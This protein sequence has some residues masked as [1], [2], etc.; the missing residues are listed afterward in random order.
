[1]FSSIRKR[2]IF[3]F[4]I[5]A[6]VIIIACTSFFTYEML[7]GIEGQMKADGITLVNN[8]KANIEGADVNDI[9]RM[10]QIIDETYKYAD[11]QLYYAGAITKDKTIVAGTA[12]DSIGEKVDSSEYDEA[13]KGKTAA[14]M[15]VWRGVPAYNVTVPIKDG[16]TIKYGLS[17]GISVDNMKKQTKNS[18]IKSIFFDLIL[19][20]LV[21][22]AAMIIGKRIARPIER[23]KETIEKIG[24]GDLTAEYDEAI[25][26]DEI[27]RLAAVNN[28]TTNKIRELVR[29]VKV[30]SESLSNLSKNISSG[31]NQIALTSEGIAA[32]VVNVSEEGM[33]QTEAL[34]NAVKLLEK[35]SLDLYGVNDKLA[36]LAKD[37]EYIREDAKDGAEKINNL[38]SSVDEMLNSFNLAKTKVENLDETIS[39]INSIVDVINGVASQTNLLAL[40]ASIEAARAGEAGKGFSV[41]AQEIRKLAEEVL[42]S[43]KGIAGL[44]NTIMKET[45]EVYDTTEHVT[46]IAGESRDDINN[47][48]TSFKQVISRVNDVPKEINEVHEVLQGTMNTSSEILHTVEAIASESQTMSALSQEVTASTEE[49]AAITNEMAVTAKKLVKIAAVL[50]KNVMEYSV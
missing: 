27:G 15:Y 49:Q 39:K 28:V 12:K 24:E 20:I 44:I 31:G 42:N 5:I 46:N 7:R 23:I 17:I 25:G 35:F 30:I 3:N 18:I 6:A 26:K 43:S 33:K 36:L 16:N 22:V 32:S 2:L 37:G 21:V 38:S 50:E 8:I 9:N 13:F 11:G 40:N 4:V 19:L 45:H 14:F 41:V 1:M 10:Q 47:A 29:K 34:D 48:I